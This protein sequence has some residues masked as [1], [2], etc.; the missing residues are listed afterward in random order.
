MDE[1]LL[2]RHQLAVFRDTFDSRDLLTLDFTGDNRQL[3]ADLPSTSTVHAPHGA[4]VAAFFG[5]GQAERIA[6]HV[7]QAFPSRQRHRVGATVHGQGASGVHC[8]PPIARARA[9]IT[10]RRVK[11]PTSSRRNLRG[12]RGGRRWAERHP[13]RP[14]LRGRC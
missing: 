1:C 4:E 9:L 11:T 2:N 3:H 6:Q 5:A 8:W 12:T 10:A 14:P 7:E 13:W